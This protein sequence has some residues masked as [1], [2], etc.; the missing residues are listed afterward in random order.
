MMKVEE[1]YKE[2]KKITEQ[3]KHVLKMV[4]YDGSSELSEITVETADDMFLLNELRIIYN[5]LE[6]AVIR[7]DYLGGKVCAE[8]FLRKNNGG[9]YE[10]DDFELTCGST[11]EYFHE[12]DDDE[13]A[14]WK[15][16]RIEHSTEKGYYIV[17]ADFTKLDDVR[18]RLRR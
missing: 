4:D 12:G 2:T 14:M 9:R 3:I 7:E 8:G 5:K 13:P 10:L 17:G 15:K 16:G 6:A 11:V 18:V 1:L